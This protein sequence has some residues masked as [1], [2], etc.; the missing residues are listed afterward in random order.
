M[1]EDFRTVRTAC[2][3]CGETIKSRSGWD[4]SEVEI[5]AKIGDVFP[6]TDARDVQEVDCCISCWKRHVVPALRALGFAI[7]ERDAEDFYKNYQVES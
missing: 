3:R 6:E 1:V 7:Q 5:Q 4:G 2:D